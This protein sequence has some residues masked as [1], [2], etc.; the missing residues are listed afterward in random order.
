MM[1]DYT[2]IA[3]TG[4]S[5]IRPHGEYQQWLLEFLCDTYPEW[6]ELADA[7]ERR[8]Y[9]VGRMLNMYKGRLIEKGVDR[10]LIDECQLCF[11]EW[12]RANDEI[13]PYLQTTK[14]T[15]E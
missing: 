12:Q 2:S 8:L 4:M 13:N 6:H 15:T 9:C 1:A 10:T 3:D 7:L 5:S 11:D 14:K